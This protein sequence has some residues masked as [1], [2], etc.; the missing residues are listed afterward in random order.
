MPPFMQYLS[1]LSL[2]FFLFFFF[3]W[4]TNQENDLYMHLV[5]LFRNFENKF[6][7]C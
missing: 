2:S 7:N 6:M 4:L 3:F 5:N 1:D